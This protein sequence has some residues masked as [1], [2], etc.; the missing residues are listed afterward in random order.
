ML[1][2][3]CGLFILATISFAIITG[4]FRKVFANLKQGNAK[5]AGAV[6]FA[7]TTSGKISSKLTL[8]IF[9]SFAISNL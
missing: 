4:D 5:S 9:I 3:N 6:S 2:K 8:S 7:V 1:S